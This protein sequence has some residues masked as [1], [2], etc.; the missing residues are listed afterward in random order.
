MTSVD[1]WTRSLGFSMMLCA[2]TVLAAEPGKPLPAAFEPNAGQTD[3][4][5]RY[6]L[7][8]PLGTY[9]FT[10][11]EVVLAPSTTGALPVR[12]RF[13]GANPAPRFQTGARASGTVNYLRG[14]DPQ[15]WQTGLSTYSDIRYQD[16]YPGV[17]LAYGVDGRPLKSTYTVA[18]GTDPQSIRWRYENGEARVDEAGRLQVR[19][20]SGAG[21]L[22]EEAPIAWLD[23]DG[24]RAPVS[25]RY[26][27]A[28]DGSV[29]FS[30]GDYDRARTLTIDPVIEYST[31]LGGGI[32]DIAL[33]IAVDPAGHAYITGYTASSDFPTMNAYQPSTGG[34][35]DAFVAKFNPNGTPAY[36]TYLG[37]DY[38]DVA[39]GI[40]VDT[41]GNAYVTGFTG[42]ANFPTL[43]A[44]QPTYAG[45]WDAFVTKLNASGSALVY[46]TYLGGTG[47]ENYIN[48]GIPGRIAVDR[49]GSA[50][51][52][53]NTQSA[54]FPTHAPFQPALHGSVDAFLSKLSADGS[55]L[56]YSTYLGGD[57]GDTGWGIT[58][59]TA[60]NAIVTGDTTSA[61]F[62]TANPFQS[63]CAPSFAGCWDVFVTKFNTAGSAL[64]YSTYLG[65]NDQEYI[66]RG[67]GVAVDAAGTA[68]VTGMTGSPN[69]P[70]LNPHQGSYGGQIDMFLARFGSGGS[71]LSSTF[72]GGSNS[73]VGNAVAVDAARPRLS[74]LPLAGVH[75]SGVTL[76]SD[77]P[78]MN[79]IQGTLGGFEDAFVTKFT[80]AVNGL[81]Y[82]TYLGGT[83]GRE[84]YGSTGI[85]LDARGNVYI[86]GGSEA[87]DYPT[88][89]PYQ[90]TPHGSYDAV[91]TRI[92]PGALAAKDDH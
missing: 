73:D 78:V 26:A 9:F 89:N 5:V 87:T 51:V 66:D 67:M 83:N 53:G 64:V 84:E 33:S 41:A 39:T 36:I 38:L 13:V 34:F 20:G 12:M 47:Q 24:R 86:T 69:F 65:G 55:A 28:A 15:R 85:G 70:V 21:T 58:V 57:G 59:D 79:P 16:L 32:F 27:V 45:V 7:R 44:L 31:F 46:S 23:I 88:L 40:A 56:V 35:D 62:P 11:S 43:N 17:D 77:F 22:T 52:T 2:T 48:A 81:V 8:T 6:L 63:Q 4:S 72:F 74:S 1:A 60:G 19:M 14:R 3:A 30:V 71:L 91:L 42:S 75:V 10:P 92:G 29:G 82:S 80:P 37:G 25:V 49:A 68:Y 90:P 61:N 18:P 76:S 50:Y 54:D